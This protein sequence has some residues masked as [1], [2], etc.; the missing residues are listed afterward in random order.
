MTTMR[1][2]VT[3]GPGD[4]GVMRLQEVPRPVPGLRDV[5]VRNHASGVRYHDHLIR[6]GVMKRRIRFPLILGHEGA[7]VV[8]AVAE[9]V[10]SLKPG[11]RVARTQPGSSSAT[12]GTGPTRRSSR[13]RR[14]GDDGADGAR[15]DR[16]LLEP[17]LEVRDFPLPAIGPDWPGTRAENPYRRGGDDG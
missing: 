7:G 5:L 3:A 8:E 12:T 11:D 9:A 15:E 10:R 17:D 16:A 4:H 13:S 6:A 1:A 14:S 2:M